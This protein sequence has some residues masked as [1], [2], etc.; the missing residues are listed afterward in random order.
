MTSK[1][2]EVHDLKVGYGE[3]E[4]L[5]GI[6][7]YLNEGER[8]GLFGPNGHGKTTLL[9]TISGLHKPRVGDITFNGEII[10]GKSPLDIVNRG[11]IQVPQGNILFPRMTVLENLKLGAYAPKAWKKQRENLEKVLELFPILAERRTQLCR[12]LSGGERQ[13]LAIGVGLMGDARLL[14]LDEPTL[15][16][17]PK[18]KDE[19]YTAI[20]KIAASGMP[21]ILVEQDVEFLLGLTE[22]LYMLQDGKFVLEQTRGSVVLEHDKIMEMYFGST[23]DELNKE[24]IHEDE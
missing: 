9:Q 11:I 19:L 2:L 6:S 16:L 18:V 5:R 24:N 17:A 12:T 7:L 23:Q 1:L 10:S 21:L 14:M 8:I 15:G 13:M 22:R 20:K 3:I 4:V